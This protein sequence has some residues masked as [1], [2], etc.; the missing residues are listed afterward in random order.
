MTYKARR[1]KVA[2]FR[3]FH[4]TKRT[5]VFAARSR[6]KGLVGLNHDDLGDLDEGRPRQGHVTVSEAE[7]SGVP[8]DKVAGERWLSDST[9][10]GTKSVARCEF[11]FGAEE[12]RFS[13]SRPTRRRWHQTVIEQR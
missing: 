5:R 4:P 1:Q 8:G 9:R 11:P 10:E 2:K 13:S 7:M 6:R 12:F 3:I